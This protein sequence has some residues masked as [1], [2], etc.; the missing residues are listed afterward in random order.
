MLKDFKTLLKAPIFDDEEQTLLA[1]VL[2]TIT[3]GAWLVPLSFLTITLFFPAFASRSI[4]TAILVILVNIIVSILL[5]KGLIN[6]AGIVLVLALTGVIS[7]VS[8]SF[9]A[10]PRPYI[11]FF[12]WI[13]AVA[14]L[15]LG[16]KAATSIAVYFAILQSTIIILVDRGIIQEV[17]AP[18]SPFGNI[19]V[20]IVGFLLISSTINLAFNRIQNLF[21]QSKKKELKLGSSY[22][23]ITELTNTLEKR[24]AD[25]TA[26]LERAN[27][28]IEKRA[29]QFQAV[30]QVTRAIITTQSLQDVLPQ[31]AQVISQQFG[32]YHIGIFLIDPNREYAVLSASNSAGGEKML[33][34]SHRLRIGQTGI[35]GNVAKTGKV[36]IALD[37]GTDAVYFNNPHLPETRSEMALPLSQ[38]NGQIIG[39]LDI[40]STA[41]NAFYQEDVEILATL[42]DQVSIAITNAR[43][44][45]DTQKALIEAEMIYRHDLKTGWGKFARAQKLTGIHRRGLKSI[46][47][48]EPLEIAGAN[49]ATKLG[50]IY[51]KK[52]DGKNGSAQITMPM[53]LRGEVVGVLNLKTDNQREVSS[54]EMDIITAIIERAAL[55]IEN[56]RLLEDSRRIAEKERV[57]GEIS[58]KIG[59]GIEIETILKT[60]VQELGAQISGAQITVE[61]G[62]ENE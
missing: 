13:I 57:I 40:Q 56:A 14:G 46:F 49:E 22:Q 18:F 9:A 6:P 21:Q 41:P 7:Y 34:R 17:N 39:V 3:L 53:K 26:E 30:S 60:A 31:I 8:I 1:G 12:A 20:F 44:Y 19:F 61:I 42:A 11:L 15:L 62:G 5:R 28:R 36:R 52:A 55:S 58:A 29:K 4:P 35:V 24:I 59:E 2:H 51:H 16:K 27:L 50:S 37:T 38:A 25:R 43:L 54:D 48:R 10:Q 47:L 32:F 33:E 45:E 23:E